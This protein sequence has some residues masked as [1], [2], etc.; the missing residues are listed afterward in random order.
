MQLT[1]LK[2]VILNEYGQSTPIKSMIK[3]K[4]RKIQVHTMIENSSSCC[5][6]RIA[7]FMS[8]QGA[9]IWPSFYVFKRL[10]QKRPG[11]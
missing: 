10:K 3:P 9:T 11:L 6:I 2:W 5:Q 8:E 4:E 7:S 1:L